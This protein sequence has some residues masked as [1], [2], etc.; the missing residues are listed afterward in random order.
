MHKGG[1]SRVERGK[2]RASVRLLV[3]VA[4]H[5]ALTDAELGALV[6]DVHATDPGPGVPRPS[7]REARS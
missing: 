7:S 1:V 3:A 4:D 6:R 2:A 5:Y